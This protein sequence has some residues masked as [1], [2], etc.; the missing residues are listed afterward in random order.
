MILPIYTYGSGVLRKVAEPITK[1]FPNIKEL[2]NNMFETMHHAEGVGLAA[3]QVG[4]SVRL[5]VIDL[6]ALKEDDAELAKFKIT[7]LNPEILEMSDETI[8][9]EEGC[10]SIPGIHEK[11]NRHKRIKVRYLDADFNERTEVFEDYRARVIQHEHDHLEGDMFTD[12]V[13]PI[14]R[15]LIKSKL[16]NIIKGKAPTKY[17]VLNK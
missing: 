12:K 10:L 3:P 6:A 5:L 4:L 16:V 9:S 15:Q 14:R 17:K 8:L 1:D 7:M 2:I 13:S 11:I